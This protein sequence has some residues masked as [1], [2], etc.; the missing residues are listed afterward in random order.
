MPR[1]KPS[2]R[3]P[4]T[5]DL[6]LRDQIVAAAAD[7]GISVSDWLSAAARRA[8]VVR[9]GLAAVAEWEAEHGA[10]TENEMAEA[11]QRVLA[12]I[13]ESATRTA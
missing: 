9:N 1:G 10:F 6:D 12:E 4:V 5:L 11:R 8:L 7:E 13:L 2:P 3:I